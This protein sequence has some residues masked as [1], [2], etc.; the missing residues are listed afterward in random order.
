M[1]MTNLKRRSGGGTAPM[2]IML[3]SFEKG[4]VTLLD[5][6]LIP[7]DAAKEATNLMQVQDGRW[8]TRWGSQDY[9][10]TLGANP[11]GAVE[12]IKSD[13]TTELIV[14]A[15]GAVKRSTDG[16]NWTTISGA[17]L[18]AGQRCRFAQLRNNLYIVNG[19]DNMV[20]YNGSTLSQYTSLS[21]PAAPTLALS[22][23]LSSGSN[24]YYY[25]IVATNTV[26]FTPGSTGTVITVNKTRDDFKTDFTEYIDVT[27]TRD[28]NV[29]RYDIYI[30]EQSGYEI[31]LDSISNP[32]SGATV[33]Y[34]D[35]GTVS[36]NEFAEVPVDNTTQGPKVKMLEISGNRLW[37][38]GDPNNPYRIYWTGAGQYQGFFS[39]FYGGGWI[40][41]EKGGREKPYAVVEYRDGKGTPSTVVLT[42]DPE[43]VGSVWAVPLETSSVGNTSFIT[44]NAQKLVK[45]VGTSAAGSVVK[46]KNDI[47]FLNKRGVFSLGTQPQVINILSTDEVSSAIRPYIR[48]LRKAYIDKVEGYYYD[49]KVFYAV[50][51]E[52][53]E[54]S[55]IIIR[56]TER[57][58]WAVDWNIPA[59]QFLEYTDSSGEIHFLVVPTTGSTLLE[60]G[61]SFYGDNGTPFSTRYSSPLMPVS[62]DAFKWSFIEKMYVEFS[63]LSGTVQMTVLGTEKRKQFS[64]IASRTVSGSTSNAGIG[65]AMFGGGMFG[66]PTPAPKTYTQASQK[67]YLRVGKLLNNVQAIITSSANSTK[68]TINR[69]KLEGYEVPQTSPPPSWRT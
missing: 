48:A 6:S 25:K 50:P 69:I 66:E 33:T 51:K 3:D 41:L 52:G 12:Y 65:A 13:G 40:D 39:S 11:D 1:A 17:T 45:S 36:P 61:D 23:T 35:Y 10:K 26:G 64:T 59:K 49:A 29:T 34:R 56:D 43:G 46:V 19:T 24:L 20:I 14:V 8:H 54:N 38:T 53:T 30:G 7:P 57:N 32:T 55:H 16:G 62:K 37:G 42:S 21:T 4:V 60:L 2:Q 63:G 9:G 28:S 31:Y 22:A 27:W 47:F 15:G 5:E 18:T 58:N 67:E 44:P 68:Y